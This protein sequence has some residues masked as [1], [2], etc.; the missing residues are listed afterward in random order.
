MTINHAV[1][2]VRAS[3]PLNRILSHVVAH[4]EGVLF[5]TWCYVVVKVPAKQ[6]QA[7]TAGDWKQNFLY[8][9][10]LLDAR[11]SLRESPRASSTLGLGTACEFPPPLSERSGRTCALVTVSLVLS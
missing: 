8:P 1:N 2:L 4:F 10:R 6:L 3:G 9:N 11:A 7:D 5:C